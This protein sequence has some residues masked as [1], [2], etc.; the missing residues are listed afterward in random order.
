ME[1]LMLPIQFIVYC[2]VWLFT[3]FMIFPKPIIIIALIIG[4]YWSF[5]G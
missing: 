3:I 5:T 2:L 4:F 1:L